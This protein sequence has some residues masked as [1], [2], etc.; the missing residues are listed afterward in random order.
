[1]SRIAYSQSKQANNA[2]ALGRVSFDE[3]RIRGHIEGYTLSMGWACQT[4]IDYGYGAELATQ[5]PVVIGSDSV[6]QEPHLRQ[7]RL[8]IAFADARRGIPAPPKGMFLFGG[9]RFIRHD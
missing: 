4:Y 9:V 1:M 3:H 8:V 5:M 6:A 2:Q 7:V